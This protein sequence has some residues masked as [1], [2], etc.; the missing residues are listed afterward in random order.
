MMSGNE[1]DSLLQFLETERAHAEQLE[2]EV[3]RRKEVCASLAKAIAYPSPLEAY[4]I[5]QGHPGVYEELCDR[6]E[7]DARYLET[8]RNGWEEKVKDIVRRFPAL[9]ANACAEK[10]I[11]LDWDSR[12]PKYSIRDGFLQVQVERRELEARV[13]PR[14]GRSVILPMEVTQVVEHLL[15]EEKRLF[16]KRAMKPFLRR[17]FSAYKRVLKKEKRRLGDEVP[18]RRVVN[19]V[20]KNSKRFRYDEFNV[21]LGRLVSKGETAIEGVRLHLYHTRDGR[22]GMLLHGCEGN[23]FVGHICFKEES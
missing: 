20:S 6:Q 22:Q 4:R 18:L 14:D 11:P 21:D 10:G 12:H 1:T 9:F 2:G 15:D 19:R 8:F 3:R 7:A 17:L 23:G 13:T 5:I 16:R